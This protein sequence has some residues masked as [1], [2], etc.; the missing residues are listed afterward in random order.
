MR[1]RRVFNAIDV[2]DGLTGRTDIQQPQPGTLFG[3]IRQAVTARPAPVR[4]FG[5]PS[6][7]APTRKCNCPGRR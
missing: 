3:A 2:Q 5:A 6:A 1:I 4:R 7:P